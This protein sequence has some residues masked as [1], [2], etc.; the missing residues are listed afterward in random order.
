MDGLRQDVNY[1]EGTLQ[2]R[3]MFFATSG[4]KR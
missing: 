3:K 1:G 4:E 2:A